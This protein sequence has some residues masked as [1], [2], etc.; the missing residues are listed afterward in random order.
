MASSSYKRLC[1]ITNRA[2]QSF[3]KQCYIS[4]MNEP[5]GLHGRFSSIVKLWPDS[6]EGIAVNNT[7]YCIFMRYL[8]SRASYVMAKLKLYI[9]HAPTKW[10]CAKV[11]D[12][13]FSNS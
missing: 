4:F 10:T 5:H 6:V 13:V 7:L 11:S 8:V 12:W 2:F 3:F 9:K 1:E